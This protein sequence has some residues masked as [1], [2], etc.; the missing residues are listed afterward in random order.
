M[1]SRVESELS[2]RARFSELPNGRREGSVIHGRGWKVP[3]EGCLPALAVQPA[4]Q[5]CLLHSL[6]D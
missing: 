1:E 2:W 6:A 5:K 3:R 4:R